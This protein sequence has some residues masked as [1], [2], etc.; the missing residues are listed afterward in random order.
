MV[1]QTAHIDFVT[2]SALYLSDHLLVTLVKDACNNSVDK[3]GWT[4]LSKKKKKEKKKKGLS[5]PIPS[6]PL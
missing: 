6:V 1:T 3:L 5:S 2:S 4:H